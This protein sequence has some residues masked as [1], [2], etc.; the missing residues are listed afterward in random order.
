MS[1]F[2]QMALTQIWQIAAVTLAVAFAARFAC[3]RRPHLAYLLWLVVIAK[4]LT[5]P[6][7]SS[8]AGVFS[9]VTTGRAT[10]NGT[11]LAATVSAQEPP[12][13]EGVSL[14]AAVTRPQTFEPRSELIHQSQTPDMLT[15]IGALGL[16]WLSGPSSWSRS[17]SGT[18]SGLFAGSNEPRCRPIPPG[19]NNWTPARGN[20]VCS[21]RCDS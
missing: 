12:S 11:Q 7:W 14:G 19:S 8:P 10:T 9:W 16:V 4:C 20:W 5:P 17:F 3:R 15:A 18:A 6:V 1:T 2:H 13:L 21:A